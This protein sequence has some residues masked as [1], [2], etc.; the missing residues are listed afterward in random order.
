MEAAHHTGPDAGM[1]LI[2][3][4]SGTG[5][6]CPS[7]RATDTQGNWWNL[8]NTQNSIY[9]VELEEL[10]EPDN[11]TRPQTLS[12]TVGKCSYGARHLVELV[13]PTHHTGPQTPGGTGGTGR[14]SGT[15][16]SHRAT[17]TLWNLLITG[18]QTTP[19]TSVTSGSSS[20]QSQRHTVE[21]VKTA[22][23]TG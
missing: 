4:N 13:E 8:L 7:N 5:R 1:E 19:A 22:Y 2:E 3:L 20:S 11:L 16:S 15:C 23:Y 12:G 18:P 9:P 21:L 10:V 17:Y 6:T 14:T